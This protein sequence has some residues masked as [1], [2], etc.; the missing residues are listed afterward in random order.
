MKLTH[1]CPKHS[2]PINVPEGRFACLIHWFC[3]PADI[4]KAVKDTADLNLLHP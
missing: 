3:L 2:C 1:T 4:R